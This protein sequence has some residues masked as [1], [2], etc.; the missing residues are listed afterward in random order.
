MIQQTADPEFDRPPRP[1]TLEVV[2][3]WLSEE[4]GRVQVEF[5]PSIE[6]IR[7]R[8][9]TET[10]HVSL[11]AK[12]IDTLVENLNRYKVALHAVRGTQP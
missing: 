1:A 6:T 11:D 8:I 4:S 7:A 12:D 9:T 2:A 3:E 10:G 5:N